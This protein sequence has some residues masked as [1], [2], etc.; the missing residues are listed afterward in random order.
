ML[1]TNR[2]IDSDTDWSVSIAGSRDRS[3]FAE[4]LIFMVQFFSILTL[5]GRMRPSDCCPSGH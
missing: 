1:L 2:C 5:F 4:Q 3:Q